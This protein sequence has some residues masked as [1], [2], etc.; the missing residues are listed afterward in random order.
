MK[1]QLL[2]TLGIAMG[3]T[4]GGALL[5]ATPASADPPDGCPMIG[6]FL[7]NPTAFSHL[8]DAGERAVLIACKRLGGPN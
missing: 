5:A 6:A 4:A 1:K 8:P 7:D 2:A 3:L